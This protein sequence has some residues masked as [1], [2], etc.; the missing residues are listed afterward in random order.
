MIRFENA[1][2]S[3]EKRRPVLSALNLEFTAG[4]TLVLGVNGSGKS[5]LLKLAAGVECPDA[6]RV[7][8]DGFDLW[9]DEVAA[10]RSL[11]YLPEFPDL[12]PYATIEEIL[13]L[14]CRLREEPPARC[15]EVLDLF[16]LDEAANRSV[17]E[18]SLGQK[19]RATFAAAF[20]GTPAN[21]LLDEPLEALD[22]QIQS[23]VLAW[24]DRR[25]VLKATIVVVSHAIEP[26]LDLATR[27]VGL[28]QGQPR[29]VA[30]LPD[31]RAAR[32]DLIDALARSE[33]ESLEPP[34]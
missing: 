15:R 24:F 16:G 30:L 27:A 9:A 13:S 29:I 4:V 17:R 2:F 6:G 20:I 3:Y 32:A 21:I 7:L 19:R 25:A 11:A 23:K 14:V 31:S 22:R 12:S 28:R 33:W 8:V 18:L 26:F 34:D 1:T 10:R 5:T